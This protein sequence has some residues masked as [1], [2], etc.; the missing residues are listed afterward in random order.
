MVV[1]GGG[2][3]LLQWVGDGGQHGALVLA[4]LLRL[5]P[6]H[7]LG[8]VAAVEAETLHGHRGL[9]MVWGCSRPTALAPGPRA[10]NLPAAPSPALSCPDGPLP[11]VRPHPTPP[12]LA[13]EG[14]PAVGTAPACG[15]GHRWRGGLH[16]GGIAPLADVGQRRQ[17]LLVPPVLCGDRQAND[18]PIASGQGASAPPAAPCPSGAAGPSPSPLLAVM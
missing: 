14:D 2:P 1:A 15:S 9:G 12:Y 17:A 13:E 7:D 10:H 8:F 11:R 5:R 6:L 18:A 3:T 4:R 16:G